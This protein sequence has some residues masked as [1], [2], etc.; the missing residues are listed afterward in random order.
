MDP[1]KS[2]IK[3]LWCNFLTGFQ[4]CMKFDLVICL[5][6][7]ASD[8]HKFDMICLTRHVSDSYTTASLFITLLFVCKAET[9]LV[10]QLC[11]MQTKMYRFI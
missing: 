10:K 1:N 5:S 8:T 4:N 3:R 6:R 11:Y 9:V 7:H 2:V